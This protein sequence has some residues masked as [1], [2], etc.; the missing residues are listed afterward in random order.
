MSWYKKIIIILSVLLVLIAVPALIFKA[1]CSGGAYELQQPAMLE[2]PQKEI[3][4]YARSE[5][6]TYLTFPEWYIVYSSEEYANFLKHGRPS[7]FP[8]AA[9]IGQFWSSYCN[10][11]AL[12]NAKYGFNWENHVMI[13]VIG[14]SYSVEL[15]F[16]GIYENTYGWLTEWVSTATEE[17]QFAHA[18]NKEYV[19]FIYDY[20]WYLFP[21]S[22]K[23]IQLGHVKHFG[24]SML[25]KWERR[26]IL[27][28]ELWIKTVYGAVIKW[29]TRTAYGTASTEIYATVQYVPEAVFA[30]TRITRIQEHNSHTIIRIPRYRQFTEIVPVLARQGVQFMNIAGNDEIFLTVV[31]PRA[32]VPELR[33]GEIVFAMPI[34]TKP[35]LKRV[36]M[37]IPVTSLHAILPALENAGVTLEHLYDY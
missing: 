7:Q 37:R 12:T 5:E 22:E 3:A 13:G 30:D 2:L 14:V 1:R 6:S 10:V 4:G 33:E 31:A 27:N 24:Q 35:E 19:A 16:K 20:P 32:W 26:N 9:S 17:D 28:M 29:S 18:L 11:Y 15:A 36:A 21:Y 23:V 8:Y 25:R 34:L